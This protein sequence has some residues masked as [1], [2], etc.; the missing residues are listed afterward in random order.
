MKA[1]SFNIERKLGGYFEGKECW[2]YHAPLDVIFEDLEIAL[3]DI[4]K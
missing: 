1:T 3:K 2:V 4:F